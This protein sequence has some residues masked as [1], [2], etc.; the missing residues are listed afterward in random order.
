MWQQKKLWH[1]VATLL[2]QK[3]LSRRLDLFVYEYFFVKSYNS[4]H[5]ENLLLVFA[6][7][8]SILHVI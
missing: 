4:E 7:L 2:S 8:N 5:I 3:V 1:V 6:C